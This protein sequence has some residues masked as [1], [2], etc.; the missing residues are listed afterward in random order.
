M[1]SSCQ[2]RPCPAPGPRPQRCCLRWRVARCT[3]S[4]RR[5]TPPRSASSPAPA[6]LQPAS[7][8]RCGSALRVRVCPLELLPLCFP[9]RPGLHVP[10]PLG[11]QADRSWG[12]VALAGAHSTHA[13]LMPARCRRSSPCAIEP[14]IVPHGRSADRDVQERSAPSSRDVCQVP[15][16]EQLQR[17]RH[18]ATIAMGGCIASR[19]TTSLN[20]VRRR[21]LPR[22]VR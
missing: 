6:S 19:C 5:Q 14:L 4:C 8:S 21:R 20:V 18:P 9:P 11:G 16:R 1:R 3:A 2:S 13:F 22:T 10:C 7:E 15:A 12:S 17:A